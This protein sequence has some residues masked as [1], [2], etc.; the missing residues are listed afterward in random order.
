MA[1]WFA[2]ASP[3]EEQVEK[4]TSSSLE[5]IAL[6]LEISDLIRSKAVQPKDAMKAL[7][8]RLE[9]KNPNIQIAT[10]QLTD[11][12]VKNGGSHFLAEVGSREF[13]DNLGSLLRIEGPHALNDNVKNKILELIQTWAVAA[14]SRNDLAYV[15]ETYRRLQWEGFRF[16]PK[17]EMASSML[18]SNAPPEW[19]DSDVCMRC[20]SPFTF[21]NR[22][23]HCR[24]CGSV[25]DSQCSS[26]SL[27]LP[28]LGILQ[29]VRVDDGCYAKLTSKPFPAPNV[30]SRPDFQSHPGTKAGAHMEPRGGRA[31][32]DFDLD[33]KRALELS[34]EESKG[35]PGG[36][37]V[38]QP[39]KAA[40]PKPNGTAVDETEDSDL[41]A[42]I[43]ASLRD[44]EDQ[45]RKHSAALKNSTESTSATVSTAVLPK[46]DYELTA[47]EAENINLLATLVD[48]LQ[49]QPP[50]TILREPQIQELYESIG[51]LRPKLARTYGE[52]MS[53]YDTLLDLHAKLSTVVRYYDRMLEDRL[54]STYAQ[55]TAGAYDSLPHAQPTS[56]LYP[57]M[58]SQFSGAREGAE[59]FYL[60]TGPPDAQPSPSPRY[61]HPQAQ[62]YGLP[63]GQPSP[64]PHYQHSQPQ[65]PYGPP[66]GQPPRHH[67]H[68]QAQPYR[69]P[70]A[71]P[72]PAQPYQHI[73][74]QPYEQH[75]SPAAAPVEGAFSRRGTQY[76]I[77]PTA[78]PGEGA[79]PQPG[80]QP[81]VP[82][83]QPSGRTADLIE[84]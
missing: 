63:E 70:E 84:L 54:S 25:F 40:A 51:A 33:L 5:D 73:Q 36:G 52:T 45:K 22:K 16:P 13:M 79:Y 29:P 19:I 72:S 61:H 48:R 57:S 67:Q 60:G 80:A 8:R 47:G 77:P 6:N 65:Q 31:E 10:L 46:K 81:Q 37:Y 55:Q 66:E 24:N 71:Q 35:Q 17:T 27:P 62:S 20:R 28:H 76:S 1:G 2:S 43:E 56:N 7:K 50:G 26:K 64:S 15:A 11:T 78:V 14:Q 74:A 39:K 34:L 32:T 30:P 82:H 9:N 3:F 83:Q 41:K 44:M 68:L 42:A 75:V 18:D 59:N 49:H 38:P 12:C 58:P 23:H 21:T 53:K 4:A 69:P